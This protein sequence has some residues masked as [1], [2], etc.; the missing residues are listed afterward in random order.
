MGKFN[1]NIFTKINKERKKELISKMKN[2]LHLTGKKA[3]LLIVM[4]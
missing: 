3:Q 2:L 4:S 1:M